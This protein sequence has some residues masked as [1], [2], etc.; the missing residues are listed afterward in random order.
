MIEQLRA[1]TDSAQEGIGRMAASVSTSRVICLQKPGP[2]GSSRG[3]REVAP[4]TRQ[5][6]AAPR[7]PHGANASVIIGSDSGAGRG[8]HSP[9]LRAVV[10]AGPVQTTKKVSLIHFAALR[11]RTREADKYG[12]KAGKF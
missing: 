4:F 8:Q 1:W 5:S 6:V 12:R 3:A 9:P 11:N 7:R 10:D 2:E